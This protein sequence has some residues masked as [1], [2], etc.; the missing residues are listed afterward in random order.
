MSPVRVVRNAT[1]AERTR[2]GSCH[3]NPISAY[4]IAPMTSQAISNTAR[5]VA[6]TVISI[7]PAKTSIS[8]KNR[9]FASPAGNSPAAYTST[10]SVTAATVTT[11]TADRPSTAS[12]DGNPSRNGNRTT[13]R[14]TAA[15]TASASIA[16]A[17]AMPTPGAARSARRPAVSSSPPA[18]SGSTGS[19]QPTMLIP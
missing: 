12:P 2:A 14:P 6:V 16:T 19:A 4:D 7:V 9:A 5:S 1:S 3:Q 15:T 8:P 13:G 10:A 18:A 17:T 11:I